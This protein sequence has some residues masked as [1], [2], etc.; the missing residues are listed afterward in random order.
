[1]L[2]GDMVKQILVTGTWI[3]AAGAV[4]ILAVATV[5]GAPPDRPTAQAVQ[6]T[7]SVGAAVAPSPRRPRWLPV[8]V[9][10]HAWRIN[11][12]CLGTYLA[13]DTCD[14]KC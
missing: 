14:T 8:P 12:R 6:G 10:A 11:S 9:A 7:T 13:I 1:M 3:A 2:E 4:L 5:G